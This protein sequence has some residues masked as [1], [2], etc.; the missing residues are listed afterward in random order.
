VSEGSSYVQSADVE[1]PVSDTPCTT[2]HH[3]RGQPGRPPHGRPR[4]S[5][6]PIRAPGPHGAR[7]PARHAG[8]TS[9][10]AR[11]PDSTA[12][13]SPLTVVMAALRSQ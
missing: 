12:T 2:P 9:L 3:R 13:R 7:A 6:W 1:V 11:R 5:P 8:H 4:P 10:P